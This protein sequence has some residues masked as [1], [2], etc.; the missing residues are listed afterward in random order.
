MMTD[1]NAK[2]SDFMKRLIFYIPHQSKT[3]WRARYAA[4]A[5]HSASLRSLL[6]TRSMSSGV[7]GLG[8]TLF[9][10]IAT[11]V[12]TMQR[13]PRLPTCVSGGR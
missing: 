6:L 10:A 9:R 7:G 1:N 2:R 11:I 3:R 8:Q 4:R 12:D 13:D 5:R